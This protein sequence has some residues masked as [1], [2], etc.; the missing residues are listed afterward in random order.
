MS[1]R[2]VTNFFLVFKQTLELDGNV[3]ISGLRNFISSKYP[4]L[5]ALVFRFH[6][7]KKNTISHDYTNKISSKHQICGTIARC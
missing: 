3:L 1:Q 4:M 2:E 7:K 6:V 5:S